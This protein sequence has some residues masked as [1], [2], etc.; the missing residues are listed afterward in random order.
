MKELF[1]QYFIENGKVKKY[2]EFS[3]DINSKGTSIYEVI[4]VIDGIPIFLEKH[5]ARLQ[6]SVDITELE[7]TVSLEEIKKTIFELIKINKI[8]N[9]NVKLVFNYKKILNEGG[10]ATYCDS[11]T[12]FIEAHYPTQKQYEEGVPVITYSADRENP[13]AKVINGILREN[14]N[15]EIKKREVYEAILINKDGILTE[16]SRSNIFIVKNNKVLTAPK[17]YVLKGITRDIIIEICRNIGLEVEEVIITEKS[18][19]DYD[20]FFITGTSPKVLPIC[21]INDVLYQSSKNDIVLHIMKDYNDI[22]QN[23]IIAAKI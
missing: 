19:K 7:L 23:Y 3:D 16:G 2:D 21:K 12:Y 4:R 10:E 5:L 9:G 17:E 8:N 15:L 22:I 18:I 13:N 14:V 1:G 6:N 20:A 11:F